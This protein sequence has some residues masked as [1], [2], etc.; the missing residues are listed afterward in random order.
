MQTFQDFRDKNEKYIPLWKEIIV[1]M[2]GKRW[3][4]DGE[5]LAYEFMG[6]LYIMK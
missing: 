6:T 4:Y 2:F 3:A 1:C 5:C